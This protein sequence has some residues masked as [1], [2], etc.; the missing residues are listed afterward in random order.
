MIDAVIVKLPK[1]WSNFLF[2]GSHIIGR[3]PVFRHLYDFTL[4]SSEGY[5]R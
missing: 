4:L 5:V 3:A 1:S 2:S